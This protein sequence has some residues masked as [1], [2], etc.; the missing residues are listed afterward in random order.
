VSELSSKTEKNG[1]RTT[2]MNPRKKGT[3]GRIHCK[4]MGEC[5]EHGRIQNCQFELFNK[6]RGP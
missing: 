1:F 4:K 2:A 3:E 5:K 6:K